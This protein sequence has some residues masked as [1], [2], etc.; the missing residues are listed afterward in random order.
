MKEEERRKGRNKKESGKEIDMEG[1]W[2][3]KQEENW[4]REAVQRMGIRME[5]RRKSNE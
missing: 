3:I 4:V 5:N 1:Q 2:K